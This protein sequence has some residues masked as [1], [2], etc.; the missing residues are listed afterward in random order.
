VKYGRSD[1]VRSVGLDVSL[2]GE[3]PETESDQPPAEAREL[4]DDL[5]RLGPTYIK[6]GQL[7]S[8]RADLLP[9]P[10]LRALARLQ[11]RV[12][13][14]PYEQV[15]EM[16]SSDLGVRISK[17]FSSFDREPLASASLGQ[18]H[19]ATLRDGR[20]VAVKVQRPGI[21]DDI[22]TDLD[23]I[24]NLAGFLD[25]HTDVG[26]RYGFA[27]MVA[28]YRSVILRE[29][30]YER[31]AQNLV[32][33]GENLDHFDSIVV[34]R[35]VHDYTSRRV[36]TMEYVEGRKVTEVGPLRE[37]E[38]DGA[39]LV[40]E[41]FRA[42]LQQVLADGFFHADPHPGNVLL[43]PDGRLALIDLG[44]VSCV[45]PPLREHLVRILLA[46]SEGRGTDAAEVLEA[47]G[48][49]T[50]DFD[51][52]QL[53][54]TV[55]ALV[56][57]H[58][59]RTLDELQP[60]RIVMELSRVSA[61]SGLRTPPALAMLGKAL[62]NLDQIAA[63][64]DPDFE[65]QA[66]LRRHV[67]RIMWSG[68]ARGNAMSAL[69]ESK[70]FVERLPGRANKLL[71]SLAN[72]EFKVNIDAIDE[73]SLI[74]GIEKIANRVTIGIILAAMILGASLIMRIETSH[75]LFGYPTLAMVLF[76][77]AAVGA[78][79]LMLSILLRDRKRRRGG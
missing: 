16:V 21:R 29:L 1:V 3:L 13:P 54:E 7:L 25:A 39:H 67:G 31:E 32:K 68:A 6:L 14:F 49:Q 66:A 55:S 73:E 45:P 10:Y 42:Y 77:A 69:F 61:E 4:A 34:P 60:G 38:I 22:I 11:D 12:E 35:P 36:L 62:L 52:A 72:N 74:G 47:I 71:D 18:V 53:R 17:G 51:G 37:M 46:V 44:M 65:P 23:V 28:E 79:A 19:R 24:E 26:R 33:L 75:E 40:D 48:E 2:N 50:V 30:D 57:E 5:E 78:T 20:P 63:R 27:P 76:I 8:T 15:E 43:T 70:E 41:L 56:D 59:D 9:E 58:Q 64:L